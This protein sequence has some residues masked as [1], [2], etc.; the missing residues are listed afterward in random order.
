MRTQ[1]YSIFLLFL[2]FFL[3][4]CNVTKHVPKQDYLLRKNNVLVTGSKVFEFNS[5]IN[6]IIRQKPNS[7][8]L[9]IPFKLMVYNL[10]DSAK[11]AN[12][13]IYLNEKRK[14]KNSKY[15]LKVKAINKKRIEKARSKGR[16]N[17]TEKILP[18]AEKDNSR[19]FLREWLKYKFAESPVIYDSVLSKKT[20]N[21]IALF[22]KRK[23]YYYNKVS[24]TN[25]V[26]R[27]QQITVNYHVNVGPIYRIDSV[28]LV[29]GKTSLS[30]VYNT[31]FIKNQIKAT[32]A[33]P[34]LNK[35]FDVDYLEAYCE[36]IAK[37]MRDA[38]YYGFTASSI[39][40]EADTNKATMKVIL[41]IEFKDRLVEHPIV[42]D[43]LIKVKYAST[44]INEVHYHLS[45]TT[46]LKMDFAQYLDADLKT[47]ITN[48]IDNQFLATKNK[49]LFAKHHLTKK[50]REEQNINKKDSLSPMRMV[51]IHYN[52]NKPS[53]NANLL[54]LQNYLEMSNVYKAYYL[55]RSYQSLSQI[56]IFSTI[57]PLVIELP[58]NKLDVHYFLTPS[59]RKTFAFEPK[60]TSSF[61]L[62]G[63][64][65][66]INYSDRNVFG[67]A[68]K[69][70]FSFGGGFESQ[71]IIFDDGSRGGITFNTFEF[72]PTLKFEIP[73]LFPTKV[74]LLSKRQKPKT[75]LSVGYNF[76]QRD[77]FNRSVFQLNYT[78]RLLVGKTQIFEF[79]LPFASVI[80]FVAMNK[81]PEFDAQILSQND[82]F[83][84]NSYSDQFIWEDFKLSFTYDNKDKPIEKSKFLNAHINFRSSFSS[85]GNLLYGFNNSQDTLLD[86]QYKIFGVGYAQFIRND[87]I[88]ILN[89][90]FN[91][92]T[93]LN[94]KLF[95]GFGIPYGNSTTSMP[96]DYS[97]FGGGANDNRGWKARTLGPGSFKYYL[98]ST[99]TSAQIGDIRLGGT[100]EYRYSL[101]S[102]LK[103]AFF[104]DF[105]NI[106]T[107]REDAARP[108]AKF[109]SRWYEQFAVALGMGFRLDLN[110][111]IIRF[112]LGIPVY[113]PALPK[114][115]RWI[116]QSREQYIQEGI[117]YYG[118]QNLSPEMN[119]ERALSKLPRAFLPVIQFGIGYPF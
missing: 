74:S 114:T 97:F 51:Y 102:S 7:K 53:V 40:L 106:W 34:L 21:Q 30:Q 67:G 26:G 84:K 100:V 71:P 1:N 32:H 104:T 19:L 4:A 69:L 73:G 101:G 88:Y 70:T 3:V 28:Y 77:V 110:F 61:G 111:L 8:V 85:A 18:A 95:G 22:L 87:N 11:V 25:S 115:A 108:G 56:G 52:G 47:A 82:L 27:K 103:G 93:S 13:R 109:A 49:F 54:E 29:N 2:L 81:S 9:G 6:E 63:V 45:D 44:R 76:E 33:H 94:L 16:K 20:G 116:T 112:D 90:A 24:S 119:R 59:K 79:G 12:K 105:G 15:V 64:N 55:E 83:L 96:Y 65:A 10:I 80:K 37:Y 98:D 75:I 36:E 91:Q 118:L 62:L 72:G 117:A 113:N 99:A 46:M 42:K 38:T 23:G 31:R 57:K 86:G 58:N 78:W 39:T 5:V 50:Q 41:G 43:S 92:K 14:L 35:P 68:E 89:K 48:P 107:Y 60:F 66:S 17:Y